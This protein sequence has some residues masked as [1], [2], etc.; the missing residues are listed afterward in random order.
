MVRTGAELSGSDRVA[1]L[2]H[3]FRSWPW[4]VQGLVW[5]L[6][7]PI[8]L[9]AYSFTRPP[10]ERGRW[11]TATACAGLLWVGLGIASAQ[12]APADEVA[13]EPSEDAQTTRP[14]PP[15]TTTERQAATTSTTLGAPEGGYRTGRVEV[16]DS[17]DSDQIERAPAANV[18]L[19]QLD[20][21]TVEA[22]HPRSGYHRSLFPQWDDEDNDGCDTRCEVLAAQRGADGMWLSEWDGYSTPNTA[23]LEVDH[24]VS[25][26]EA[27][28][29]GADRWTAAQ[30]DEFADY[31]PNLLA[32]TATSN[33]AKGDGDPAEWFPS[34]A[35][36]NCLWA[37]TVVRVKATWGLAV[38]P[39]ERDALGN[40]LRT[41]SDYQPPT[42]TTAAPPPTAPPTTP[43]APQPVADPPP[44]SGCTPG[45]SPCIP[46][47]D[48]VD[49]A[50]GSG[51]GP[52]YVEGPVTVDH[53]H[54]DPYGL[55]GNDNDGIGCE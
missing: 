29:S 31:L 19:A 50:G 43:P 36:A 21:L 1:G 42:T 38:D 11:W 37:S 51:N 52:R 33:Q 24:V 2:W 39:A 7:W 28:D 32:V 15:P 3:G 34:R 27:W 18:L 20:A 45:Y 22:E 13:T 14:E 48:D 12:E 9:A 40:L 35:D 54:G 17:V 5:F 55:D 16:P 44:A 6:A 8:P 26:A 25:L 30:R 49:C 53:A 46:P 41:C 4:W 23:E 47:G 10:E